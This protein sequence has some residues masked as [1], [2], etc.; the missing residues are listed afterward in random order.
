MLAARLQFATSIG[1]VALYA[2]VGLTGESLHYL[3]QHGMDVAPSANGAHHSQGYYHCHGPDYHWH[4]HGPVASE[5]A[6]PDHAEK[7]DGRPALR[8]DRASHAPH[9]CPL[10]AIVAK[11]KLGSGGAF[12]SG[13]VI[14]GD[15]DVAL[16]AN[17]LLSQP[18]A[19]DHLARGPPP[20]AAA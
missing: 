11:L 14:D 20:C 1:L 19:L 9:A 6:A 4:Y 3:A 2:L 13:L 18:V 5:H 8:D 16:G 7:D 12:L 15:G 10:L 17:V